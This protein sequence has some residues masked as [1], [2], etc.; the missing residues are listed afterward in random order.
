M[1]TKNSKKLLLGIF[2]I[3][4][5]SLACAVSN[6]VATPTPLPTYTPYPTLTPNPTYT[7]YPTLTPNP[8]YT[9]LPT[10]TPLVTTEEPAT[11][12]SAATE[13]SR[14]P[15]ASYF[16]DFSN[17]SSGWPIYEGADGINDY[18]EGNYRILVNETE[19]FSWSVIDDEFTDSRIFVDVVELGGPFDAEAG[20]VCRY[21]DDDNF[22]LLTYTAD[23]FY[24][25]GKWADDE[26]VVLLDSGEYERSPVIRQG[27]FPNKIQADCIGDTLTLFINDIEVAE[28]TD[29]EFT[30]GEVGLI[31]GTFVE[32]GAY[33]Y[34]D[35]FTVY[36]P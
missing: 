5:T 10:Y 34:F 2:A 22:Y 8:T 23:G 12:D 36:E 11:S 6:F 7:P 27:N 18:T 13:P 4:L 15:G 14:T 21:Q 1:Q 16:D 31:A 24:I 20:I 19:Y 17:S 3:S 30:S 29:T 9:A 28:V 26:F 32:A 33:V 25:I 35:N